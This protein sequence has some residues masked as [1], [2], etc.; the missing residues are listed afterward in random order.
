MTRPARDPGSTAGC[1]RSGQGCR[2]PVRCDHPGQPPRPLGTDRPGGQGRRPR[3]I[4]AARRQACP[5]TRREHPGTAARQRPVRAGWPGSR[6]PSLRAR[7]AGARAARQ[8]PS[9]H[10]S[11]RRH[12]RRYPRRRARPARRRSRCIAGPRRQAP[13]GRWCNPGAVLPPVEPEPGRPG[14]P[15]ARRAAEQ[16]RRHRPLWPPPRTGHRPTSRAAPDAHTPR[17]PRPAPRAAP[18]SHRC[19]LP[20]QDGAGLPGAGS[21]CAALRGEPA[22]H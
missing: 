8:R 9:R 3:G 16:N 18:P 19:P 13:A 2:A 5:A 11:R 15:A 20:V 12:A 7:T 1:A 17:H 14:W 4:A 22:A 6:R 21:G 10:A